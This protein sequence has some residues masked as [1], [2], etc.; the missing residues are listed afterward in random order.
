MYAFLK[1]SIIYCT[2]SPSPPSPFEIDWKEKHF[3]DGVNMPTV[4]H[5]LPYDNS[6]IECIVDSESTIF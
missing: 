6:V 4:N 2:A 1:C 3:R 5:V